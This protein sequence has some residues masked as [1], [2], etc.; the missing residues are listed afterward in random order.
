MNI[1]MFYDVADY[2]DIERYELI[3]S[4][5]RTRAVENATYTLAVDTICPYQTAPTALYDRSGYSLMELNRNEE[6]LLVYDLENAE[7]DFGERGRI[8]ISDWLTKR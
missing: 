4:H 1:I 7:L 3:Q 6:G 8:Q 2:D 5:I